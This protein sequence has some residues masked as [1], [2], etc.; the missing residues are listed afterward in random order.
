MKGAFALGGYEMMSR[1]QRTVRLLFSELMRDEPKI[2]PRPRRRLEAPNQQGVYLICDPRGKVLHVGRTPSGVGGIRQ[3]LK[4]HLHGASSFTIRYLKGRGA[5]L[6][7]GYKY[8]CLVVKNQWRR[9]LLEAYAIGYLCP[10]HIGLGI[11]SLPQ[12]K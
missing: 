5:K 4:N 10:A 3:R 8:R 7:H 9:A 11:P 12:S 6:R 2:F 1:E